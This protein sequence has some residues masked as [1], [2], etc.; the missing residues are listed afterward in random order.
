MN[1]NSRLTHQDSQKSVHFADDYPPNP[2]K[3]KG[4]D[5]FSNHQETRSG[6]TDLRKPSII[7]EASR[8]PGKVTN[9]NNTVDPYT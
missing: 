1:S 2:W 9:Q 4:A 7:K 8:S 6:H 5:R 3:T